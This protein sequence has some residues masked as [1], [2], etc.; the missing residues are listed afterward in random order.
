VEGEA[1][2][3]RF[4]AVARVVDTSGA[5]DSFNAGYLAARLAGSDPAVAAEAGHRL[6]CVVIGH[7]G[8]IVPMAAMPERVSGRVPLPPFSLSADRGE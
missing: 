7:H 6:A 3:V 5:G 8:A 1:R 4:A 2:V